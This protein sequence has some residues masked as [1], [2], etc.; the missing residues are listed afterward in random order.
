MTEPL[1]QGIGLE[2]PIGPMTRLHI[3]LFAALVGAYC[4]GPGRIAGRVLFI[5]SAIV[6]ALTPLWL[7][8]R[9]L[10]AER[11]QAPLYV[12]FFLSYA[13][14]LLLA[15]GLGALLLHRASPPSRYRLVGLV[16]AAYVIG[17]LLSLPVS[18][19][20]VLIH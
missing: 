10:L 4:F 6:S 14:P 5:A 15:S 19:S 16:A 1:F 3:G 20:A 8:G 7:I 2:M 18:V 9:I 13:I 11:G 12:G 17:F